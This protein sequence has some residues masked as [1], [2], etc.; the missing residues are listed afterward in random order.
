SSYLCSVWF[1]LFD[2]TATDHLFSAVRIGDSC[3]CLHPILVLHRAMRDVVAAL[4]SS[5]LDCF[6]A[7]FAKR[8]AR[9]IE[10][11]AFAQIRTIGTEI[12]RCFFRAGEVICHQCV[13]GL[14]I[15]GEE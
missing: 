12:D 5:E 10:R 1:L 6:V 14:A 8:G 9:F 15:S 3:R 7:Q 13:M 11:I 2:L 4:S